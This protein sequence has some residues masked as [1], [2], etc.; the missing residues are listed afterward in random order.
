[1]WFCIRESGK[2]VVPYPACGHPGG[3]GGVR[4]GAAVAGRARHLACGR[5]SLSCSHLGQIQT[6]WPNTGGA[7]CCHPL[8]Q[9]P[10][11]VQGSNRHRLTPH[12]PNRS[13]PLVLRFLRR[14][15][16][17]SAFML[18]YG[19]VVKSH[20]EHGFAGTNPPQPS[21]TRLQRGFEP[22]CRNRE[23]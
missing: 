13:N 14:A 19:V 4:R 20:L 16:S 15:H 11:S 1:V 3:R 2:L 5:D 22:P 21:I 6:T 17:R 23:P 10:Q 12:L 9:R 7:L 18:S 8:D